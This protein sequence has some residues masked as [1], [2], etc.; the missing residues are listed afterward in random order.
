MLAGGCLCGAIRYETEAAPFHETICHC[1]DCRRAVG[2]ASVA[3]FS[4]PRERFH[5]T[6]GTPASYRSS[7]HVTR[8]FCAACGTSLTFEEDGH[9]ELDVTTA[10][11]DD[12]ERV[13]PKDHTF[14]RSRLSWDIVC[15][16]LP[17]Y[18]TTRVEG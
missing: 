16:D 11:L 8:R 9:L 17:V 4:V 2:A 5:V 18:E 7:Q 6:V 15:D 10:S 13:P 14:A 1:D 12:A 3:W